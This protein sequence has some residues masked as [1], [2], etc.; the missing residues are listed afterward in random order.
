MHAR[1]LVVVLRQCEGLPLKFGGMDILESANAIETPGKHFQDQPARG[2]G[3]L[4]EAGGEHR[5]QGM[6]ALDHRL[7]PCVAIR[8]L[9]L[10]DQVCQVPVHF[11]IDRAAGVLE[12]R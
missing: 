1:A 7:D 5:D 9:R 8:G 4:L 10:L 3:S 11:D 2:A 12:R 6:G